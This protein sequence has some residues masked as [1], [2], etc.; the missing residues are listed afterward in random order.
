METYRQ[1][2]N[3]AV[4]GSHQSSGYSIHE[5]AQK[6]NP[7]KKALRIRC[8]RLKAVRVEQIILG[9]QLCLRGLRPCGHINGK[10]AACQAL[11]V[12]SG[13]LS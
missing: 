6:M 10:A 4:D 11:T 1:P 9:E 2:N 3:G 5:I 13:I 8:K 12:Q 7:D